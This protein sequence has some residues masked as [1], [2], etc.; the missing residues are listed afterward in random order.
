[1]PKRGESKGKFDVEVGNTRYTLVCGVEHFKERIWRENR[2]HK[3]LPHG[4]EC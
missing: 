4:V 2:A 3:Y 1:M